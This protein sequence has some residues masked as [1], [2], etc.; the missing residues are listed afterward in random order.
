MLTKLNNEAKVCRS[1]RLI[2]IGK[3]KVISFE[4]IEVA[5]VVRI[6]KDTTKSKGKRGQKRKSII[7]EADKLKSNLETELEVGHIAKE[8]IISKKKRGRKHKG[9]VQ[10]TSIL[11]SEREVAQ[12]VEMPE[13]EIV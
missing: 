3:A 1:T 7:L 9:T 10:E 11:E 13:R 8:V 4:D 12:M 5:R 2:V 6:A